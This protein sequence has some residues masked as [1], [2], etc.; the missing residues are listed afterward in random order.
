MGLHIMSSNPFRAFGI[1]NTRGRLLGT[2]SA[3]DPIRRLIWTIQPSVV[4]LAVASLRVFSQITLPTPP[5]APQF[6][7]LVNTRIYHDGERGLSNSRKPKWTPTSSESVIIF[8]HHCIVKMVS[9]AAAFDALFS[10]H[11]SLSVFLLPSLPRAVLMQVFNVV[12]I[13]NYWD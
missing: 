2:K 13:H 4:D 11:P 3:V 8:I 6:L 9:A 7:G 10:G 5:L 12:R 1:S